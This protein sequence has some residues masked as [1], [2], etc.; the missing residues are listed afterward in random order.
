MQEGRKLSG[1]RPGEKRAEKAACECW[2]QT[3]RKRLNDAE[4]ELLI[5]KLTHK[6]SL[7]QALNT[8]PSPTERSMKKKLKGAT[9]EV[10]ECTLIKVAR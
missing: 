10:M 2:A 3:A 7:S 4:L 9:G 6:V 8:P 5:S 1:N